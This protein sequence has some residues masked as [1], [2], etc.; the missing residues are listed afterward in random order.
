M[1]VT[2]DGTPWTASYDDF[3]DVDYGEVSRNP[4]LM[5]MT[6]YSKFLDDF[7]ELAEQQPFNQPY[8]WTREGGWE[9]GDIRNLLASLARSRA[10]LPWGHAFLMPWDHVYVVF[11]GEYA[12]G[13]AHFESHDLYLEEVSLA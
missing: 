2:P 1:I 13:I 7:L 3:Q 4:F 9:R 10:D 8:R 12:T 11:E 6:S 5:T